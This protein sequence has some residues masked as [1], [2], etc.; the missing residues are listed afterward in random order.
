M[1]CWFPKRCV[2]VGHALNDLWPAGSPNF[3]LLNR[4]AQSGTIKVVQ[5]NGGIAV[6]ES[7]VEALDRVN[8]LWNQVSKLDGV[9]IGFTEAG[10]K[11]GLGPA[12]M[13]RLIDQGIIRVLSKERPRGRGNKREI[14]EADAAY[15]AL[16]A[17]IRGK[18]PRSRIVTAE[19]I[20]PHAK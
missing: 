12:T 9:P 6:A 18:R 8:Q 14:N 13:Y 3:E 4:V 10:D 2:D 11:Y 5:I 17:S 20:P 16:V 15:V 7:D 1:W 19:F